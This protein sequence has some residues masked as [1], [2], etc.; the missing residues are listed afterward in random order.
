MRDITTEPGDPGGTG[1][2]VGWFIVLWCASLAF[3]V[4]L[5]F[6]LKMLIGAS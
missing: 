1:K 3:W 2:R 5:A 6:G 4:L